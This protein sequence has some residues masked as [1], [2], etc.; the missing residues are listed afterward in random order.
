VDFTAPGLR[1]VL[2]ALVDASTVDLSRSTNDDDNTE[3]EDDDTRDMLVKVSPPIY[4]R[5]VLPPSMLASSKHHASFAVV[6]SK[7]F[8]DE[9][10]LGTSTSPSPDKITTS[11][12]TKYS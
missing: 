6:P 3:D 10:V 4:I 5:V 12:R 1:S 11:V 2:D 9:Q 7:Q 8:H